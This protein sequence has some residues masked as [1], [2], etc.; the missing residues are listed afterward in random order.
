MPAREHTAMADGDDLAQL[1][2][3]P[4]ASAPSRRIEPR[5]LVIEVEM[6]WDAAGAPAR[7]RATAPAGPLTVSR[8][9][10]QSV[11]DADFAPKRPA[12]SPQ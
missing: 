1:A 10:N 9:N 5:L 3:Q 2:R 7:N 8:V 12:P 11:P 4:R 6:P